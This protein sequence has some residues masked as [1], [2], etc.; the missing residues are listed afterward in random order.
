M[1]RTPTALAVCAVM[2]L[3]A[4]ANYTFGIPDRVAGSQLDEGGF[5]N[6]TLNNRLVMSGERSYVVQLNN[7]FV[8][9]VDPT[10][11]FAFDSAHLDAAARATLNRQAAWILQFPEVRFSV[12]GHTDLV[13][14]PAYNERL[15]RR[16]AQAV[17]AYLVSRGVDRHRLEALVSFGETQPLIATQDR[18]RANRRTVTEVAGFVSSHPTILDGRYAEV[19]YRSYLDSAGAEGGAATGGD[20]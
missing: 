7:R 12:Y 1:P 13:G 11:T 2:G 14:P 16:R 15:G 18:E 17:V 4:C 6:P 10:V 3:Q 20:G 5:G 19:I 8:A 9:E